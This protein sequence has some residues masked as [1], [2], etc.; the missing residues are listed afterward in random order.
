MERTTSMSNL[1]SNL[2]GKGGVF[3]HGR[4]RLGEWGYPP[5][6][7]SYKN[8]KISHLSKSLEDGLT[9]ALVSSKPHPRLEAVSSA[10]L[11]LEHCLS[12]LTFTSLWSLTFLFSLLTLLGDRF[13]QKGSFLWVLPADPPS[14]QKTWPDLKSNK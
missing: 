9:R 10:A 8:I 4:I 3:F 1:I 6:K 5:K 14:G 7:N 11:T 13:W 2:K 12:V